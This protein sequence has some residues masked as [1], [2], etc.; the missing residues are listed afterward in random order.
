LR[1]SEIIWVIVDEMSPFEA[2]ADMV[3]QM[4]FKKPIK[5]KWPGTRKNQYSS[6]QTKI[7]V[8]NPQ[9]YGIKFRI[10]GSKK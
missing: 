4:R 9:F 6:Y 3:G 1:G 5:Q 8:S 7:K 2:W 10:G